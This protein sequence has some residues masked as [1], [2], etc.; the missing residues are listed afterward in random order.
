MQITTYNIDLPCV[1][2]YIINQNRVFM[3][4]KFFYSLVLMVMAAF[5]PAVAQ[6]TLTVYEGQGQSNVVPAYIFY[7]DDFTRSQVVFPAE[8]LDAMNGGQITALTFYTDQTAEYVSASTADVYLMEV[9]YTTMTAFE[10]KGDVLYS[11]TFTVNADG[12]ITLQ[13]ATPYQY[14]GGNLLLGIENTTD[15]GYKNVKFYG[16]TGNAGAS[17]AG[18]N[19]GSTEAVTG[20]VRDFIP[21]TTFT[22]TPGGGVIV[23][24]PTALTIADVTTNSANVSWTAGGEETS[25]NFEYKKK[26]DEEWTSQVV[27]TPS[28]ALDALTN[29]CEY[30]V[31]VNAIAGENT[32]TWV[33]GSFVTPTC[34]DADKG[35]ISYELTDSYGDGWNGNALEFYNSNGVLEATIT[36]TTGGKDAPVTGTVALCYGETYTIKWKAGSYGSECGFVVYGPGGD[37][38]VNHAQGTAPTAGQEFAT[39]LMEM[40]TCFTP[41]DLT[42]GTVTYN[43]AALSWTPG[44]E[45]QDAWQVAVGAAGFNPDQENYVYTDVTGEPNVTIVNLTEGTKYDA[46]VRGNCGEGDVSAWS[47]VASFETP[48]QFPLPTELAVSDITAKSAV[49][50]WLG[51]CPAFNLR[52]RIPA[53]VQKFF[54]E[55]FEGSAEGWTLTDADGDGNNWGLLHAVEYAIQNVPLEAKDGEYVLMSSSYSSSGALTPDNWLISPQL[56]LKGTL[57]FFTSDDGTYAEN[58]SVY[59]STTGTATTDFVALEENIATPASGAVNVWTEHSY[60]LSDYEGQQGYIAIRHHGTSDQDYIFVDAIAL[61]GEEIPETDWT[62][63]ENTTA[64]VTMQPLQPLT[65]YEVQ[66]QGIYEGG[67]SGWTESVFFTTLG[68]DAMP[69]NLF[70]NNITAT[71]ADANWEGSQDAYNLRYRTAGIY[72]GYE[73]GFEYGLASGEFPTESGWI[74]ID[75]DGDGYAWYTFTPDDNTNQYVYDASCM[76]S[77]SYMGAALTPDDWLISPALDL[78]GTL[79]FMVRGQDPSYAA[80]HYAVY[81]STGER[82]DLTSY[83]EL[84]PEA[85]STGTYE[86]ITAD[87]SD[88]EGQ[89][90]YIA[91][92]HFNCSDEFRLNIDN[93]KIISTGDVVEPGEWQVVENVNSIYTIEGLTPETKYEV[94]VQGIVDE[95]NTTEWTASTFFT[96]LAEEETGFNEFYLVG[97]FNNWGDGVEPLKFEEVEDGVFEAKVD[98]PAGNEFKVITYSDDDQAIWMGG[99]DETGVGY[100]LITNELL[101]VPTT[102]W[103]GA[104]SNFRMQEAAVYIVRITEAQTTGLKVISA[105]LQIEFIYYAPTGIYD[106]N[107]DKGQSNEWYNLNGQKLNGKPVV[108]GIYINGGKKVIVK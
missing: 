96:T 107:A 3:N 5:M 48:L 15:A 68:A 11:G 8:Q 50:T 26:A 83:V 7:W 70:V 29:G 63:V 75:A 80:E 95:Q 10:P 36:I 20:S 28:V 84:I 76:T 53:G 18:Y 23:P 4:K 64:P 57:Q 58:F 38:L 16:Q 55:S 97:N 6:E 79:S 17:F 74:T 51:N 24:K 27:T 108:P 85:V 65:Q 19:S 31:R 35:E 52:Y 99:T 62:V 2:T 34:E 101:N 14:G 56:D 44:S 92:R 81:V 105:P 69:T 94:Q 103:V 39:F 12:T 66:V 46:Y 82:T 73:E 25:W 100:Y 86:E 40:P 88:Y 45:D 106:I 90:G 21:Q 93:F 47:K 72:P 89:T 87:L 30:N 98:L 91:I 54:F 78:G 102:L 59:I 49:A 9:D 104:G 71:T 77:A 43:T 22:Y 61:N 41:K 13:L 60:D 33:T 42:V 67:V 32:S 37:E 1:L